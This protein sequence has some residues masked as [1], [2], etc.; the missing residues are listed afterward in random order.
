[1]F[2][3]QVVNGQ[4]SLEECDTSVSDSQDGKLT[5]ASGSSEAAGNDLTIE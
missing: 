3:F 1:M 5:K 2:F 4:D